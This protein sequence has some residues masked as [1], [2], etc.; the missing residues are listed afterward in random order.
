MT[1]VCKFNSVGVQSYQDQATGVRATANTLN[2]SYYN[3]IRKM[4][5]MEAFDREGIGAALGT[6]G[7]CSG[8]GCNGLLDQWQVLWNHHGGGGVLPMVLQKRSQHPV[9]RSVLGAG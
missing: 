3:A 2:L 9:A 8:T 7:T 5:R 6:W 1:D 4:L